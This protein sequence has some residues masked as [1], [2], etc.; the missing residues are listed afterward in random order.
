MHRAYRQANPHRDRKAQF[1]RWYNFSMRAILPLDVGLYSYAGTGYANPHAVTGIGYTAGATTTYVYDN[2][3]NTTSVSGKGYEW[4]YRNR[5]T[6]AGSGG[7][8]TTYA[9]DHGN[10][11]VLKKTSTATTT[12]VNMYYNIASSSSNAT[13]TKHILTPS[14]ELLA[15]V[16]GTSS[17]ATTTYLHLD[18]LGGTNVATDG[19]GNS[20]QVLDYYPYGSQRIATGSFSEQRR[21]IGEEYDAE[22]ENFGSELDQ[23]APADPVR[24]GDGGSAYVRKSP[25]IIVGPRN[26]FGWP[27]F[28]LIPASPPPPGSSGGGGW[29]SSSSGGLP[30]PPPPPSGPPTGSSGGTGINVWAVLRAAISQYFSEGGK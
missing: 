7:A 10:Q 18:H 27:T 15:T 6:A 24:T 17:A 12:F 22:T 13:A 20:T 26:E 9:Y 16:V 3:E 25:Q 19:S 5:L 23:L 30:P 29:S 21:F 1:H 4:D 14:G 11:R 2:N 8:T 28:L